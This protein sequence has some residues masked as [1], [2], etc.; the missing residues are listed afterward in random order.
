MKKPASPKKPQAPKP[1]TQLESTQDPERRTVTQ[2]VSF[3]WQIY[4]I[5]EAARRE[6][7]IE[8]PRSA[9]IRQALEEKFRREGRL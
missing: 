7:R 5:M 2:S 6:T 4:E 1:R 9:Y 8:T 3:D